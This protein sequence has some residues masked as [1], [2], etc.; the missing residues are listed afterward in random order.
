[1]Q[2]LKVFIHTNHKQMLGA[3][4]ARYCIERNSRHAD[5]FS[6]EFLRLEDYPQLHERQGQV[7]RRN[8]MPVPWDN[9]DLQSF[10]PLRFLP[11]QVMGYQGRAVVIDPD[12]FAV[13]DIYDLLTMPMDEKAILCRCIPPAEG[14]PGYYATSVML[15]DCA[16]LRSWQW[17]RAIEE[18]FSEER[19]YRDWMSL[20]LEP[21][22]S[23]GCVG[24]EWNSF[25]ELGPDTKLLHNTRRQTQP[26][27]TG[28]PIDFHKVD[29]PPK[30]WRKLRR[31]HLLPSEKTPLGRRLF[32][33]FPRPSGAR[34]NRYY[35]T[36]P[37]PGQIDFFFRM[38]AEGIA[39]RSIDPDLVQQEVSRGHVR[40]DAADLVARYAHP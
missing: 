1:M 19:D 4:V 35:Q 9:E 36:H 14:R 2:A 30:L 24:E 21:R 33:L 20:Y 27:K 7:Y 18:M 26:W 28:L 38:L 12:V 8:G 17:D 6:V 32:R 15:L 34:K 40:A 23:I 10:T 22:D 13:G 29:K 16:S 25:D 39:A 3:M 5:Q 37:D 11:P 31:L